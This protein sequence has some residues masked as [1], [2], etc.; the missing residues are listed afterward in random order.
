[1]AKK[2]TS[3]NGNEASLLGEHRSGTHATVDKVN[4]ISRDKN[5]SMTARGGGGAKRAWLSS[6]QELQILNV[7]LYSN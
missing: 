6:E 4:I 5:V 2:E 1:M 7:N 3:V